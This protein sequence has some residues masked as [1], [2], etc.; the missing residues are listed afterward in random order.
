MITNG[1]DN[2]VVAVPIGRDGLLAA[3]GSSTATDG[4]G[5]S[6]IDGVDGPN[7]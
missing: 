4:A 7:Y 1:K 6:G 3:G 5:A 2:A